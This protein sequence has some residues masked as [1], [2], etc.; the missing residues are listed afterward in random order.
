VSDAPPRVAVGAVIVDPRADGPYIV[1]ARRGTA[2]NVGQW[3]LPGGKVERGER[4]TSA[5]AR[6]IEEEC[7]LTV[8]VGRLLEVVE[9]IDE[10]AHYV[11]LDYECQALSGEL[12][13]GDD[14]TEVAWVAAYDLAEYGVTPAVARVI[15]RA[16][17]DERE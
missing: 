14:V 1:L 13:A 3:T 11:I 2:P 16:V 5:L 10:R 17:A 4:L 12:R 15:S 6:E 8:R 7:G 9:L